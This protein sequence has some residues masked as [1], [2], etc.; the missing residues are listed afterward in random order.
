[1]YFSPRLWSLTAGAR[2]RIALAVALGLATAAAGIARLVLLGVL[3]ARVFEGDGPPD[4][5]LPIT[6]VLAA[7]GARGFLQYLKEGVAYATAARVQ[8]RLRERLHDRVL[9]LGPAYFDSRRTGDVTISLVE[10]VEQL[11]TF[12]GQYLPQFFTAALAPIGI[13]AFMAFLDLPTATIYLVV[14][15]ATLA[16]PAVFHR[17]NAAASIRRRV[18]YGSFAADFLDSIQ[19]LPTLKAFGQSGARGDTL[20]R[21]A[22]AVFRSTMGVL[23]SNAAT[24][25]M[26]I[27]GIAVGAAIALSYGASRVERGEL[28]IDVL[29]IILMLG[30]EVFRPLRELSQL[31]HQGLLGVSASGGVFELLAARPRVAGAPDAHDV[32]PGAG[33]PGVAFEGVTFSY[34]GGRRPALH[35]V[36]FRVAPGERVAV[37]GRSGSGKSTLVWLLQRL[38]DPQRG[39]VLVGDVDV[40]ALGFHALRAQMAVV[41]QDSYLFHGTIAGNLRLGKPDATVEELEA[42]ARAANA[43]EFIARLPRGYDTVIGERGQRLSG[44]ERQRVAIARALLRDAPILVLDEALSS[45]DAGNEAIIQ[46]ALDRLME[47]RTT[48]VI[49]HRLSSVAGCDR[50]LVLQDGDL[51][52]SGTPADLRSGGGAYAELMAEQLEDAAAPGAPGPGADPVATTAAALDDL[53]SAGPRDDAHAAPTEAMLRAE[54]MGWVD[55]FR[56]LLAV[57]GSLWP[58]LLLSFTSGVGH[59]L[60]LIG[61]SVL[62]ALM[63]A[64]VRNGEPFDGLM[65][66]LLI[67]APVTALL[68]WLESWISHDLAFRLLAQMRIALYRQLDRLAPGYLQRR[69]TGDLV[70]MATQ[71]VETV[72]Y[73]FAHTVANAFVAIVVPAGVLITLLVHDWQLALALLPFLVLAAWSPVLTRSAVERLG[74]V[75]RVHLG[76]L[77]AHVVDT[78]QG[79]REI[80]ALQAGR[81]RRADF[82]RLVEAYVPVRLAFNRQITLQ[83]VWLEL[84]IGA[85]GLTVL[86]VGAALVNAGELSATTLPL[87]TLLAMGAFLPISELAQVGRRLGD[88]IGATRRLTAIH[89][90]TVPVLDGPGVADGHVPAGAA[91]AGVRF[92]YQGAS[93]PAL[94]EVSFEVRPGSTVALVGPSGAGKSTVAHQLLRFWDPEAGSV[95]L[96]G[97]DA[98]EFRLDEL[99]GRI[100]LVAQDTYLFNA[101][102]RDNLLVANPTASGVELSDALER[103]GL[104]D[105][106]ATLPDGVDTVVGERGAQL[107]G[108]QRQRVAIG[109]AILKDAPVLVLDEATSHLDSLNERLV[110]D[111]LSELESGRT[112]VVIAH[113][114]STVRDTDLIVVLEAGRVV[115]A[116]THQELLLRDGLYA[117]LAATQVVATPR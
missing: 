115:E 102:I 116:G 86:V 93:R 104:A 1:M 22:D 103:A 48:L 53:G 78:L 10:G 45:V 26:T 33:R 92:T 24:H 5:V 29:L 16:A 58:K 84:L 30:V 50:I 80:A 82:A 110:R 76:E 43:H 25:G 21:R 83:R 17:M 20:E 63:V 39:R 87:L 108:G 38:Y 55:T 56:R 8:S 14:A 75:A 12:F 44:G 112:A 97:H 42:A 9:E 11:E 100:A 28:S 89:T 54:Q 59:F 65:V 37:V 40:R 73:F 52:E 96:D 60:G 2:G 6:A 117:R 72:E 32:E 95:T 113:R 3:L 106:V 74:T 94:D 77:N 88:T 67:L 31:F 35:H 19:G 47:G 109:R 66:A 41:L 90:E 81:Q 85:G 79:L 99:R 13:F 7:I 61:V 101:S 98:R 36:S 51:V 107:S 18:A 62:G 105:F 64:G 68:T 70:A 27:A 114:L 71:D 111:A 91:L 4:L 15:L 46:Q 57:V 23:A 34:P 69:R 49:A